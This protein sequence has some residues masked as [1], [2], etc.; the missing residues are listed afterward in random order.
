M[1]HAK[2]EELLKNPVI[3]D[4]MIRKPE[5]GKRIKELMAKREK[6]AFLQDMGIASAIVALISLL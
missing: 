4:L 2:L 5:F 6:K 3:I 1:K